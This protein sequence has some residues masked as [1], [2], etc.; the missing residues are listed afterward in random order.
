VQVREHREDL[1]RRVRLLSGLALG[2]LVL[3]AVTFWSVQIV[4][5]DYYRGLAENNRLR[6]LPIRAPRGL[7]YDREGRLLVENVPSYNLLIDRSRSVDLAASVRFASEILERP[8][9][10]LRQ[11]L[12]AA[13]A[14]PPFKPAQVAANLTLA[15]V[16]RFE[17]KRL[18]HPEFEIDVR[19]L[20]LYRH[21]P[22]TAHVLGY[23]GEVSQSEIDAH[24][25]DYDPGDLV[26]KKGVERT[27]DLY[28]RGDDGERVA[29]VDSRGRVLEEYQR[30]RAEAGRPLAL[31]LDLDLQQEAV[32]QMEGKVGAVVAMDPRTGEIRALYSAPSY[33]AN[34]LARGVTQAQWQEILDEPHH[35]LQNRA[36][37]N[38]YSPG[39]VFKMVMAAAGLSEGVIDR[40]STFHCAG[41]TTIYGHQFRCWKRGGHGTVNLEA[42]IKGSCDIYFYNVGKLLGIDRIAHYSRLFGLGSPTGIELEGEK[43]GLVPDPAWSL[44]V[45]KHPWYPGETISVSIGQGPLLTTPLQIA[46]MTAVIANDGR[47]VVPHLRVGETQ[48]TGHRLGLPA[49][50]LDAVRRGLWGVVNAPGGTAGRSRLDGVEM[51]GKTGTVQVVAQA[52]WGDAKTLP[53]ELRDHA[54]FAS[55]APV[56]NPELVVVVFVEH[57]GSGSGIAAPIAKAIHEKYFGLDTDTARTGS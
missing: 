28:L 1:V 5:G 54:W 48:E 12:E 11:A 6:K 37:Q 56:E 33:N 20:R 25:G 46:A 4:H 19:H 36:T 39:S 29:V 21:G 15:Q 22:R 3:I 18:E 55:F 23:L 40:H 49:G 53:F 57:G 10:E 27:Y 51:A 38:T 47:E 41:S 8:E 35:P 44:A 30:E 34:L 7:I 2:L 14:A 9:E 24:P 16:G 52:T 31:S 43:A 32:R 45:R 26:G 17:A 50:V 13:R 42:A